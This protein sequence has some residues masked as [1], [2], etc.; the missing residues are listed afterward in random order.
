MDMHH[1]HMDVAVPMEYSHYWGFDLDGHDGD[2]LAPVSG[3]VTTYDYGLE[4]TL[5]ENTYPAGILDALIFAG[6]DNPSLDNITRIEIDLGHVKDI[7]VGGA[8]KGDVIAEI[9]PLDFNWEDQVHVS[10]VAFQ[11]A[12]WYEDVEYVMSP[13]L[14]LLDANWECYPNSPNDC[15][16]E[17]HDYAP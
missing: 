11:V 5:S 16:P 6:V 9:R 2:V 8:E 12:V 15:E 14:F 17:P 3:V 1:G 13:T 4:I 10:G 7:K